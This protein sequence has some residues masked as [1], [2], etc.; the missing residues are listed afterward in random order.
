[1]TEL[2]DRLKLADLA[3]TM[4]R[5]GNML[6]CSDCGFTFQRMSQLVTHIEKKVCNLC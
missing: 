3:E 2:H 1:M 4:Q 6:V 5:E